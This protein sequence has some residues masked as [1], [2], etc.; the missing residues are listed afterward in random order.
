VELRQLRYLDAVARH[1]SFTQAARELHVAQSALSQQVRGLE[2]ELGV[3][4]LRRTTR[5]VVVTEPGELVLARARR[6][7][8]EADGVREELD[9]LRG[10]V[11]GTVRLGGLPPVGLARS[12]AVIAD[13]ARAHPGVTVT[14]RDGAAFALLD[15]LRDGALDLVAALVDPDGL[16]GLE[17]VRLLDAELVVVAD[18]DHAFARAGH[19]RVE[20]LAGE[21]LITS[22]AG[23]VLHETLLEL[24]PGGHVVAEAAEPGAVCELAASGLGVALL[25]RSAATP[26]A[27]RV[28]IRPL[29]PR[30]ALPVSLIWRAGERPTSATDA[31]REHV[32]S[33]LRP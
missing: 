9:A 5:S 28:A 26:H 18:L 12:A 15:Q 23:S 24:A 31:F 19:V 16:A 25:P 27:D 29:S 7:L 14:V 10:L 1:L 11:R 32:L 20:R 6:A 8:A 3:E 33:S 4:L 2:R 13:F 17:G 30:H 21:A 22:G